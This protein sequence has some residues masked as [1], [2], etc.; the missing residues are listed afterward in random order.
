MPRV[1]RLF[2]ASQ[3]FTEGRRWPGLNTGV[4]NFWDQVCAHLQ[5]DCNLNEFLNLSNIFSKYRIFLG[6]L[7]IP[8]FRKPPTETNGNKRSADVA[9][10]EDNSASKADGSAEGVPNKK[11]GRSSVGDVDD[12]DLDDLDDEDD[13]DDSLEKN[14]LEAEEFREDRL[15]AF[16]NDPEKAV[17][18]F[19]SSYMREKG[20]IW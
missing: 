20:L 17:Q 18:I 2:K 1:D 19:L 11:V 4:R 5:L 16:L 8:V 6:L 14:A 12:D 9:L 13:D 15:I 3:D 10:G 7:V